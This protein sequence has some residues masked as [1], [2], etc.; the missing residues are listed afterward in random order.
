VLEIGP[1]K[2]DTRGLV[3]PEAGLSGMERWQAVISG[4][5]GGRESPLVEGRPGDQAERLLAFLSGRGM[6]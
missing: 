1:A 4:G 6:T 5:L 2:P 3:M